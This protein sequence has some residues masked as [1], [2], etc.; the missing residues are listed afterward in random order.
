MKITFNIQYNTHL[1]ET[2]HLVGSLTELGAWDNARAREMHCGKAGNHSL[3]IEL[4]DAPVDF[5][6]TYFLRSGDDTVFEEWQENR[7][8]SVDAAKNCVVMDCRRNYPKQAA[9]YSSAFAGCWFARTPRKEKTAGIPVSAGVTVCVSAATVAPD[10]TLVMV[11]NRPELGD[12]NPAQALPM[13]DANFPEWS[14]CLRGNHREQTEYKFCIINKKDKSL[15]RWET[16]ENRILSFPDAGTGDAVVVSGL[17]FRDEDF[18]WKCAGTVVPVFAL[19]SERSCGIGDFADLKTFV[20]W[21]S[22]TSQKI[23]QILPVNDTTQTRTWRDSYPYSAISIFALHP[24]YLRLDAMGALDN[25]KRNAFYRKKQKELNDLEFVDYE[26]VEQTK[27]AFFN[28]IFNQERAQTIRSEAYVKFFN[29]NKEWL[30][31]YAS[32]SHLRDKIYPAELYCYLQFHLHRQLS[33]ARDYAHSKGIVLKG[34]IPIGIGKTSVEAR[35]CPQFFN[36]RRQAGAPP[37]DFSATGQ[38]WGF[39]TYNWAEMEA[40]RFDWWKKRFA[41]M[42]DYFDAYR[43]DHILGF[44]RIWEIPEN[45]VQGLLGC[46]NPALPL[47]VEEIRRAG[48]DFR[49]ECHTKARI[50]EDFLPELFGDRTEE[51]RRTYLER[52]SSQHFV[53]KEKFN[54]QLKIK[55]GF[56]GKADDETHRVRDG[57]YALCNEV[58]FIE[59][60]LQ[61]NRFH[62]RIAVAS[63]FT[64]RELNDA[65]RYA[66]DQLYEDYFYR[67]HNHFWGEAGYRKLLPLISSTRMLACGE[68]LGM[69]PECVPAVMNRL[70]IFSLELERTPKDPNAEFTDLR[71][72]PYRSVCTTSTH[73]MPTIRMWWA[74]NPER[75]QRYYNHV[76]HRA[77]TAP[78]ECSAEIC[79]Q[80]ISNHLNAPSMLTI[81]PL[82]DW[83][84]ID[85]GTR[86][87]DAPKERINIP[88]NPCHY[89][90]YRM[91]LTIEDLIRA[92]ELNILI[93]D[94]IL[95]AGR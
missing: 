32:Y 24:L 25:P 58:L 69:I 85:D 40:D 33:E 94:L 36:M 38:N 67:R 51:V 77:G 9:F 72:L 35:A 2:L 74:E 18:E 52:S 55:I 19:R 15:V 27:W 60:G 82:Q 13:D 70:Q 50:R 44:F 37:D 87:P 71:N 23:L 81:V 62:P 65:D 59:D 42:A 80:M 41:K 6:Y 8:L 48:F 39:P 11:G 47:S 79:R 12:W 4:P 20:D 57:L 68:D 28:E 46:F 22:L 49:A 61:P 26:Q 90:R 16:G 7:R 3:E 93:K 53:L 89:W 73:D 29:S 91:H 14:C 21:L 92:G 95:N 17:Q 30:A 64:Y 54:T 56:A 43:I 31:P 5:E 75:T 76:L 83:L 84:S 1:G 63:S 78:P 86:R 66:F 34:D 88:A 45:S 10:Q